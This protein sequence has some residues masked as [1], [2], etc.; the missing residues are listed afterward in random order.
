MKLHLTLQ[1]VLLLLTVS[2]H[3]AGAADD[4]STATITRKGLLGRWRGGDTN[5]LNCILLFEKE[6]ARIMTFRGDKHL[7]NVYSWYHVHPR[8]GKVTLGINGEAI[9]S[10]NG[11]LKLKLTREFPHIVV[12]RE[13]TLRRMP[14]TVDKD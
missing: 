9:L 2:S 7:S 4:N 5:G 3:M 11:D 13:A 1:C 12:L 6:R 14:E 8:E 10:G